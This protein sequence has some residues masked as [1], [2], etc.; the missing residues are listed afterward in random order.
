[1]ATGT[2]GSFWEDLFNGNL[3]LSNL[4]AQLTLDAETPDFDNDDRLNDVEANKV[5][6]T[7]DQA[8]A[9]LSITKDTTNNEVELDFST[10]SE[11]WTSVASGTVG[12]II[13]YDDTGATSADKELV[14]A[15]AFSGGTITANG[16]D[17]QVTLAGEGILKVTYG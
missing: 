4:K 16:S 1:M 11:T 3:D 14:C 2:Y 7:T 13:V 6:G 8:L 5:A 10:T 15:L 9:T 17:I 12:G